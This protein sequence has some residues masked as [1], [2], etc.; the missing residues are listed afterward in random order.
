[1]NTFGLK[2]KGINTF[3]LGKVTITIAELW[4]DTINF[5]VKIARQLNINNRL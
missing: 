1:M 2:R 4:T 5:V 3:W